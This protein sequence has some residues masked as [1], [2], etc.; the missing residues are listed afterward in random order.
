ML[1]PVNE[2]A[3]FRNHH[4]RLVPLQLAFCAALAACAGARPEPAGP[5]GAS[6]PAAA[7]APPAAAASPAAPSRALPERATFADVVDLARK[8]DAANQTQSDAGCLIGTVPPGRLAADVLVAARPLAEAP[9]ELATLLLRAAGPPAIFTAWGSSAGELPDIA[10][11][12]FT[13]TTPASAKALP[14][15]LFVTHQG[16]F[17]RGEPIALRAHPEALEL[18]EVDALLAQLPDPVVAYLSAESATPLAQIVEAL[19]TLPNR[20]EVALAVVLPKG[21]RLPAIAARSSELLC[22]DG[23]PAPRDDESEGSLE[24]AVLREVLAP[25]RDAALS[26]ALSTGGLALQGGQLELGLRI[27]ADGRPREL[28]MIRDE[29]GEL[30]LRRCVIEATRSL[31]FPAPKPAGFVDV[32]LPIRVAL[33][34]PGAQKPVCD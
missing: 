31:T 6:Q 14:V 3:V 26:C 10:L 1:R 8:L 2:P 28:C 12:A 33:T 7:A 20:F 21:T 32:Q 25:L 23:L 13:T 30:I 11:A 34:G 29:I 9:A 27:G 17:L 19:Q 16:V 24:P 5:P 18:G 4:P 22:P 15:A